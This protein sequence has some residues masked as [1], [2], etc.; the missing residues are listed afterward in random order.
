VSTLSLTIDSLPKHNRLTSFFRYILFIPLALVNY[1]YAIGAYIATVIAWFAI[2]FTG[3]YPEGLYGFTSGY[4]RFSTRAISYLML[5][6]DVY[7]PF[8]GDEAPDY[9]VHV[10]IPARLER[11]SRLKTLFRMIYIIPAYVV[12][13]VLG[14][15]LYITVVIS[16]FTILFTARDPFAS[17]KLFA[18][19]WVLKFA[20]LY[21]LVVED[22]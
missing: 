9:P 6:V 11:Y 20:A 15:G 17:F 13:V 19:G 8:S 5:A 7:P 12:V 16:W 2:L 21:L 3:R 4:L 1:L 10:T 22:Y 18:L 14:I